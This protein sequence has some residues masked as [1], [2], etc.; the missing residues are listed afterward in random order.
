[1]LVL[2]FS[3]GVPITAVGAIL[4]TFAIAS[5]ADCCYPP[6]RVMPPCTRPATDVVAAIWARATRKCVAAEDR[7]ASAGA[8]A[9]AGGGQLSGTELG[10]TKTP[11]AIAVAVAVAIAVTKVR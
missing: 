1:V 4:P 6:W 10:G 11:I 7:G 2:F 5:D 8:G 9:G 3:P